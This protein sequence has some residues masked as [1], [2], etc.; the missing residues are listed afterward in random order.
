MT[1][2][3]VRYLWLIPAL[4]VVAAGI[5]ALLKRS[6]RKFAAGIAIASMTISLVL[7][8]AAFAH[9]LRQ[10]ERLFYNFYWMQ[11]GSEW[12]KLGWML[13]PLAAVM[14]VMVTF[15]GLLIF[16]YSVAYMHHDENFTRFFCFLSLFAGAML[17]LL[18][19]NSLLLLFMCWEVVGLTSYLLIGFWYERPAAAAAAKKAFITTRIGDLGL[20][21]GMVW[22]YGQTGTLLFYDHGAGCME[23][24]PLSLLGAQ[25]STGIALLIFCGAVG[26]LASC[27]SMSGCRMRWRA[28]HR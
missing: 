27:R 15:V 10:T 4:P 16:I 18:I 5:G 28:P 9:V 1:A 8:L 11:F 7:A 17:G 22:L 25:V 2:W 24:G 12:V 3:I 13:D 14:L 21:L 19:A 26:N 6:H 23:H 20:L